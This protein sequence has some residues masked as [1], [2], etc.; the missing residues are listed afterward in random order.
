MTDLQEELI[1][2]FGLLPEETHTL[3]ECHRLRILGRPLGV[4]KIDAHEEGALF[5]F[6]AQPPFDPLDFIHLLQRQPHY[7]LAGN[8]RL[9]VQYRAAEPLERARQV[10]RVL[11]TLTALIPASTASAKQESPSPRP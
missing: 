5:Q 9:R 3:I 6:S 2:R 1:D 10:T 7:R 4:R 8:D 11:D